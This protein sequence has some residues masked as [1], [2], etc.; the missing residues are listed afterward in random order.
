MVMSVSAFQNFQKGGACLA[1][2]SDTLMAAS[3]FVAQSHAPRKQPLLSL[4][5]VD[6]VGSRPWPVHEDLRELSHA[7]HGDFVLLLSV[8]PAVVSKVHT[9]R[10]KKG[11][12]LWAP[13][14][15]MHAVGARVLSLFAGTAEFSADE[16]AAHREARHSWMHAL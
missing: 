15:A 8:H 4:A 2:S 14:H 6:V 1:A 3:L 9:C 11:R 16:H 5:C 12:T 7:K 10:D 13:R